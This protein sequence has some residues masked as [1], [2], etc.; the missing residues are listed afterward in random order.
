MTDITGHFPLVL[1]PAVAAGTVL[2]GLTAGLAQS[3]PCRISYSNFSFVA[4]PTRPAAPPESRP[5]A[6]TPGGDSTMEALKERDE[7]LAKIRLEQQQAIEAEA[8]LKREVEA[9]GD[10]RRKLNTQLIEVAGRVRSLEAEVV[11]AAER[12]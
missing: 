11:K 4:P 8:K 7:Q 6:D 9:I 1:P 5:P 10:D 3:R 12:L 2:L